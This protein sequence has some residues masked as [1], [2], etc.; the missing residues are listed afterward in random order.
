VTHRST[1]LATALAA[2][3]LA[4]SAS[5]ASADIRIRV[6]GHAHVG[7][8]GGWRVRTPRVHWRPRA[9]A[10][11]AV[12]VRVGGS[13]WLGGG[14]YYNRT[15][16]APPPA[17][18]EC[19]PSSV[20]SYYPVAPAPAVYAAVAARPALPRFGIGLFAGGVDVE[21]EHVGDDLGVLARLRLTP[22]LLLEGEVGKSELEDGIREDRRL[23]G[24]LVWEIGAYNRWAPYLVG[25]LGVMQTEVGDDWSTTQ[26]FGELG[27]GLRWAITPNIH[28]AADIRAGSRQQVDEEGRRPD[29]AV[30]RALAPQK[31]ESEEYTRFR[32]SALFYF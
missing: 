9:Y 3:A 24:G 15:Y 13:I 6:G 7:V 32:A 14:Y 20:P 17:Y 29:V 23:G 26:S 12:R 4:G 25:S 28:L 18:C 2:F 1:L 21:G 22:G 5:E 30:E 31:D 16:A 19:G 11:P 8:G 10:R 27:V